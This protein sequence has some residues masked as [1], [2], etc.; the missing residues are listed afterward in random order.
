MDFGVSGRSAKPRNPYF[1]VIILLMAP[2]YMGP[3]HPQAQRPPLPILHLDIISVFILCC[4]CLM[5]P[6]ELGG[7]LPVC[8]GSRAPCKTLCIIGGRRGRVDHSVLTDFLNVALHALYM[9]QALV[10]ISCTSSRYA[11]FM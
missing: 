8:P 6:F 1:L 11:W 4:S 5:G 10:C 9:N 2:G 3:T 7:S